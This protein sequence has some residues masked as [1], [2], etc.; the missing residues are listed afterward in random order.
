MI[1]PAGF[2]SCGEK[3][4]PLTV[5]C[6]GE[7]QKTDRASSKDCSGDCSK[8]SVVYIILYPNE[9]LSIE[10]SYLVGNT[11]YYG[12]TREDCERED[13]A[14]ISCCS[15]SVRSLPQQWTCGQGEQSVKEPCGGECPRST[16]QGY[17]IG[18]RLLEDYVLC[19]GNT[20]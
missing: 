7:C 9:P 6:G 16:E 8:Q 5:P 18:S 15:L 10:R 11:C 1:P 12:L 17:Y 3:C 4:Q 13:F 14:N 20:I 19:Q 2:W